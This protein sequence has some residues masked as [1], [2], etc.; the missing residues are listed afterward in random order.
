MFRYNFKAEQ[1]CLALE[2]CFRLRFYIESYTI[3]RSFKDI[4]GKETLYWSE[5]DVYCTYKRRHK[6]NSNY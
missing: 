6:A 5:N 4:E 3:R 2:F 1:R